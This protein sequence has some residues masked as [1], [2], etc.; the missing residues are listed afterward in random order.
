[1]ARGRSVVIVS[2]WLS[3]AHIANLLV[4]MGRGRVVEVG[5][6]AELVR[7]G[8]LCTEIF[9]KQASSWVADPA[10]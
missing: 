9:T 10:D 1:M 7:V 8:V 4:F 3:L 2:H 5:T 6:Q